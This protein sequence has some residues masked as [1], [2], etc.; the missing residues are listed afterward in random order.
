MPRPIR[1]RLKTAYADIQKYE[2][3]E[4]DTIPLYYQQLFIYESNRVNRN[5][6]GYGN[7]QYNYD[8]GI[9][10][11]T[12]EPDADG[13]KVLYT[14]T[15][16]AQFF[17]QPWLNLGIWI[18]NKV[19]FDHLLV[20][21]GSLTSFSPQLAES[22]NVSE[23]GMTVSF[24]L[25]DGLTWHDGSP[26]TVEDVAWSIKTAMMIPTVN[27]VVSNTIHSIEG[28]D[29]YSDGS[30]D[31][32][33]G[34]AL[35]GNTITLTFAKLDPNV[36]LTFSQFAPLP[37]K[38]F[39]D[40]DPLQIQQSSFWQKPIGSGPFM[41]KEVKMNDF[42][43]MVPFPDYFGGVAKIDEIV[44]FPSGDGDG[45]LLKNAGAHK[46]DYGFTKNTADVSALEDM[47]FMKVT[48]AD[49]PYTRMMWINHYPM[50]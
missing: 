3:E 4:L 15:A 46:A 43:T 27:P 5:G 6:H 44:A 49:I 17:E 1:Q 10:D 41:V 45:N 7:E 31:D 33:S 28:A 26:L 19:V 32:V 25:R 35:D 2:N 47:D 38:Y 42:T 36:L 13:K 11:W 23:D 34:I 20:A 14:N 8:W 12:V 9:V 50:K 29:A 24:T 48:P 37:A 21:D 16:P 39:P 22:Y 40:I 30:A 18:H